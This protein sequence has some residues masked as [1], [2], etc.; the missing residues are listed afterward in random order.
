VRLNH[1]LTMPSG[2]S[3]SVILGLALYGRCATFL[4]LDAEQVTSNYDTQE[5]MRCI[6]D[7]IWVESSLFFLLAFVLGITLLSPTRFS[8][9]QMCFC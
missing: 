8:R 4:P 5:Y 7:G 1:S 2:S 9:L 3:G 6:M